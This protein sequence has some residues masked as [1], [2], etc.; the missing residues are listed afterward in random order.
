MVRRTATHIFQW[1]KSWLANGSLR[2]VLFVDTPPADDR[3]MVLT[4]LW[5]D[6]ICFS[7]NSARPSVQSAR[8]EVVGSKLL[9][10]LVR[11]QRRLFKQVGVAFRF[12]RL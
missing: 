8:R 9:L 3:T 1:D 10:A 7:V 4:A 2:Q 6:A 11:S 12:R 5:H